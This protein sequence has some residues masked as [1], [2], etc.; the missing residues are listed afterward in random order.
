[1]FCVSV[2]AF[3]LSSVMVSEHVCL[4]LYDVLSNMVSELRV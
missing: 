1:L 2:F 4:V 3:L